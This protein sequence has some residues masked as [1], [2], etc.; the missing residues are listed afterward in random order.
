MPGR[1]RF[2]ACRHLA[3]S[4]GRTAESGEE[5][6]CDLRRRTGDDMCSPAKRVARIYAQDGRCGGS[7][8][9]GGGGSG[10]GGGGGERAS[11]PLTLHSRP[12]D[13]A[14][15]PTSQIG[16]FWAAMRSP[17]PARSVSCSRV[18]GPPFRSSPRDNH[19]PPTF[20]TLIASRTDIGP[21][22]PLATPGQ[23]SLTQAPWLLLRGSE[24]RPAASFTRQPRP[25]LS[26]RTWQFP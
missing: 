11:R 4:S 6:E 2:V 26:Q 13:A 14:M 23:R 10:R 3:S 24:R 17:R 18:P 20:T 5:V 12:A 8:D 7:G 9:A 1:A 22:D 16:A 15:L 21:K 19:L 25:P